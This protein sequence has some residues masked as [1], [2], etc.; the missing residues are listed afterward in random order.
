MPAPTYIYR[1][2]VSRVIDGDTFLAR[3]D[4]GFRVAI[5]VAV[6][7]RNLNTPEQNETGGDAATAWVRELIEGKTVI[8]ESYKDRRSFERWVCDVWLTDNRLLSEAVIEAGH[9]HA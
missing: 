1:A 5:T 8:L 4:L 6:R 3:I 2:V 7:V 9:G